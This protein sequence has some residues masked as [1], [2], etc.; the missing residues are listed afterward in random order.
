MNNP[1]DLLDQDSAFSG[2][3]AAFLEGLYESYL[4]NPESVDETWRAQFAAL[5]RS[6]NGQPE[7]A[8]SELRQR[9]VQEAKEASVQRYQGTLQFTLSEENIQKQS[10]VARLINH[11]RLRGHQAADN[12]PLQYLPK[13]PVEDLDP[14]YFGLGEADMDTVFD[15]GTL[16]GADR[17]PLRDILTVLRES[18]C[19]SIGAEYLHIADTGIK[20]WIKD[21]LESARGRADLDNAKKRWLL[22]SLTAAD[23]IEKHLHQ[24]YVGQKRF[25]L[26]GCDCL[27]PLMDELVQRA[28]EMGTKEIVI[29]MAHRGRLNML[30]NILG[31][32]P[33]VLFREFEG[34]ADRAAQTSSGDVKYHLGYSSDVMS[35]GGIVHL[36]LAF[37]PSH[38]ETISAV[39]LGSV[40]ARQDR[41]G[42]NRLTEVLPV[43][44]HGDASFAGQ[45]IVME[46]L[47]MAETRAYSVGGAVH[48]VINNQIGF[49]TSRA[50]EAR[51]TPYC[52]DVA[53]MVQ[54]PVF[55]VNADDPEA[56]LYVTQLA[57]DYRMQFRKD[58]V[59]DLIGYRRQGHNEADEPAVTQPLMYRF[60][61]NRPPV[62]KLYGEQLL[63]EGVIVP[64]EAEEIE[65]NYRKAL[66]T[67]D[68]VSRP[69]VPNPE[70]Y[71]RSWRPY[72]GMDWDAPADTAVPVARL[73]ALGDKLLQLP[74]G[75]TPHPRVAAILAARA[76]MNRGEEPMDWGWAE[77]LAYA[78]L[79]TDGYGVRISGQ[80]SERGTFFHRHA[81]LYDQETGT[82][83]TPLTAFDNGEAHFQIYNSLLSEEGVLGFEYGY[84]TA[85][86]E[87]LVVWEAQFGDFANG[88]QVL[89]DQ[90][91]SS[92]EA[93]WGLLCHLTLLLPHG[94]EGQGPEHS[95]ARLERYLQLCAEHNIQVC[96]PTTPAQIFHLLRR[97]MLRSCRKPLVVLSPKSL[98]RHKQ[99]VS[100]LED[101]ATGGFQTMLDE[102]DP[103]DPDTVERVVLCS[104]KV[105]FDLLE[106]R[107]ETLKEHI[108]IVRIEQLYPF[109]K[110][111][112]KSILG[113]YKN[114]KQLIWCQEEPEN[115]GAWHRILHRI[116]DCTS[117]D[118]RL[119]YAGRP[120]S[121]AP[122][123]GKYSLHLEQQR[124]LVVDALS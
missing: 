19:G 9:M 42:D 119:R 28:G 26:E 120:I 106:A 59:I 98:L 118:M 24:K 79:L 73:Q 86:P 20:C 88:A 85:E 53:H 40:R 96:V 121:A 33:A 108:A 116:H 36:A 124:Q 23:G 54:I 103:I 60:I 80:D 4:E 66:E 29:G 21:R 97:Q 46:T 87:S 55:H 43:L 95:S 56:V 67:Q 101:L 110:V 2:A 63:A 83:H 111:Q 14:A 70:H 112:F 75:F 105:Y 58:V 12:N 37:N 22:H 45:G 74:D 68:I 94:F 8:H 41:L 82:E 117:P 7:V 44:I 104:G 57:L 92:A 89:I 109:P 32:Q 49:T 100:N 25:S 81:V 91:L 72:F 78:S 122:A 13:P 10:A 114:L 77:T 11:Y 71:K 93:K 38:L 62:H 51:S 34:T 50:D 123:V 90:F 69:I 30:V 16:Y 61:R 99:A 1:S 84:A 48:I 64:G 102:I 15:T 52:T 76:R 6:A 35:R 3:N 31:K 47:N 39:V 5:R 65:Q 17:L 107:R 113:R 115:Q 18:Y 27:I